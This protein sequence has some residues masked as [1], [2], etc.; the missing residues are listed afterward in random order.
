M[1]KGRRIAVLI[2]SDGY[3]DA[4]LSQLKA[5]RPDAVKLEKILRDESIGMSYDEVNILHNKESYIILKRLDILF[6][7]AEKN[8]MILVYFAGHGHKSIHDSLLYLA[9]CDTELDYVSSTTVSAKAISELMQRSKSSKKILI[10][11]CCYSGAFSRGMRLRSSMEKSIN[12][13]EEF[14]DSGCVILTSSSAMQFAWEGSE[15]IKN[16][17]EYSSIYTKYLIE[18]LETWK[19]DSDDNGEIGCMELHEYIKTKMREEGHPQ[20]P[21][22]TMLKGDVIIAASTKK[23]TLIDTIEATI[24]DTKSKTLV[25]DKSWIIKEKPNFLSVD[26]KG[27]V[28]TTAYISKYKFYRDDYGWASCVYKHYNNGT[29]VAKWGS[30]GSANGQFNWPHGIAIDSQ[31][32]VYVVDSS[33]HRIQKFDSDGNFLAE[34]GIQWPI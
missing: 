13:K 22:I 24:S 3:T 14:S 31:D 32:H 6:T 27:F 2:A 5:P 15:L 12:L 21:E 28:Y 30:K 18:G 23:K 1:A 29:F 8:D 9:T 33:N 16:S 25:F 11:D 19:A 20:T 4:K 7:K 34:V 26:S 10:L 17:D